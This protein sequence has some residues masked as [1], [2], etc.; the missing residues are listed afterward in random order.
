MLRRLIVAAAV[1]ASTLVVGGAMSAQPASA[2]PSTNCAVTGQA[3]ALLDSAAKPCR[4]Q[5]EEDYWCKYCYK[6]GKWRLKYCKDPE[7]DNGF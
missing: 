3:V 1:A 4:W 6:K 7:D 5:E 2:A